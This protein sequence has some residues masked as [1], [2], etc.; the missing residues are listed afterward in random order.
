MKTL[1][2]KLKLSSETL[3]QLRKQRQVFI[4][5]MDPRE[6]DSNLQKAKVQPLKTEPAANNVG[7]GMPDDAEEVHVV[8]PCLALCVM[9]VQ[10]SCTSRYD[11]LRLSSSHTLV[12][13]TAIGQCNGMT[14]QDNS[15]CAEAVTTGLRNPMHACQHPH[16]VAGALQFC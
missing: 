2:V 16:A 13:A 9:L 7:K 8:L 6:E 12:Q 14:G 3:P 1:T 10:H 11:C 15:N 4:D 5:T